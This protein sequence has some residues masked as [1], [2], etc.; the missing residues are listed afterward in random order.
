MNALPGS[1]ESRPQE[2]ASISRT[3]YFEWL[4]ETAADG[5]LVLHADTGAILDS[6]PFMLNLLGYTADELLEK[7]L[8]EISPAHDAEATR[9]TFVRLQKVDRSRYTDLSLEAKDG[10][11]LEVEFMGSAYCVDAHFIIQCNIRDVT[12]HRRL[13]RL[14]REQIAELERSNA[15]KA[16]LERSNAELEQFSYVA[17]H[18]LQEP[19]RAVAGCVQ[20]LQARY[21]GQLDARADE[22]IM[23]ALEGTRR[24]ETLIRDLLTFSRVGTQARPAE[25]V[26]CRDVIGRVLEDLSVSIA[27]SGARIEVGELPTIHAD[28]IQLAQLFQNLIGNAIKFR[29]TGRAATI[30]VSA[31][32]AAGEWTFS[33]TDNGI[34][35]EERQFERIFRV[36]QRLHTRKQYQGTGIGLAICKKIVELHGGR[37][38]VESRVSEGSTFYFTLPK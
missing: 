20:L 17:S 28:P 3:G 8:W 5:I 4:F 27:E 10:R 26:D 18:D 11:L 1:T 33:V 23:H 9:Q 36:F 30:H 2:M 12:E 35:I 32:R 29:A 21:R 13:E 14:A 19:L 37:L 38:W 7:R 6:N 16:E 24:M 22:L 15:E 25:T 31:V 34:G